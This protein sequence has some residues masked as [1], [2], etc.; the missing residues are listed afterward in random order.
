MK[1]L[2]WLRRE[3]ITDEAFAERVGDCTAHAVK[4]WKYGERLP[5]GDKIVRIED[6]TGRQVTLR[7]LIAAPI[8]A[9]APEQRVTQ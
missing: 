7:D 9:A 1:L 4:K 6:V 8:D 5:P 2:D 3:N